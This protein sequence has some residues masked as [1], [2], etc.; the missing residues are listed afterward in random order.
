MAKKQP[1]IDLG[2]MQANIEDSSA[3][4]RAAQ[5]NFQR[6]S[7]RLMAAQEANN[8]AIIS[9]NQGLATV[10]AACFVPNLMAK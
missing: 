3:E 2:A 5:A 6:A 4:L 1:A 9:L 10:K 7:D 8:A